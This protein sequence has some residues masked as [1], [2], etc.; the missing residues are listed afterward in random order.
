M[1]LYFLNLLFLVHYLSKILRSCIG[2]LDGFVE[3]VQG[4]LGKVCVWLHNCCFGAFF[5]R[6]NALILAYVEGILVQVRE[7]CLDDHSVA[8]FK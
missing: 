4:H 6:Y 1:K 5:K 7:I 8:F 2:N 3:E